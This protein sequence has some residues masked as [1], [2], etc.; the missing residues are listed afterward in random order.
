MTA[1]DWVQL[2]PPAVTAVGVIA[3]YLTYLVHARRM[4]TDSILHIVNRV[5]QDRQNRHVIYG[6]ANTDSTT[7]DDSQRT[8]ADEV[9]RGFD[10]VGYFYDEGIV[11]ESL[12]KDFY[13]TPVVRCWKKCETFVE[14]ERKTR[15][16]PSHFYLFEKLAKH[17]QKLRPDLK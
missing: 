15:Q 12:L 4:R 14:H 11:P 6:I 10:L 17:C 8:A 13:A 5:E 3:A 16:Q 2:I 9:C 7:W 1:K